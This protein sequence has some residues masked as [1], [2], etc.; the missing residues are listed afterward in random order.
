[1]EEV[2]QVKLKFWKKEDE[3]EAAEEPEKE[4]PKEDAASSNGESADF[5]R[6][7]VKI[8]SL[9]EIRK[10]NSERFARLSE[11]IG[12]VRGMILDTNRSVSEI[13]LKATKTSDLVQAVQPDKL[14]VEVRKADG[15]V[16]AVRANIESNEAMMKTLMSEL[17]ELRNRIA[18]FRG[19][20]QVMKLSEEVKKD[21]SRIQKTSA[22]IERHSD[23][24]ETIFSEMQS[25]FSEMDQFTSTIKELKDDIRALTDATD[26][27]KVQ[28]VKKADKKE[29]EKLLKKVDEFETHVGNVIDL[30]SRKAKDLTAQFKGNVQ[31]FQEM[32]ENELRKGKRMTE[33]IEN[34]TKDN[35]EFEKNIKILK[36]VEQREENAQKL[37]K[38]EVKI[39]EK[40][41]RG[42]F[43][44]MKGSKKGESDK[45][46][47]E[48]KVEKKEEPN[49]EGEDAK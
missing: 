28:T 22:L 13:E 17:K 12:E 29:H 14:M 16:E 32:F 33:L 37:A 40:K 36:E 46:D 1:M 9:D 38:E 8:E 34:L 23:K 11:Q 30:M 5:S 20:E 47:S 19:L 2:S 49:K 41:D 35:P 15:K 10:A 43:G 3:E 7:R 48:K 24:A 31:K 4:E 45:K 25:R 26:M 39:P 44:W 27:L 42:W 18:F 21:L 6:L